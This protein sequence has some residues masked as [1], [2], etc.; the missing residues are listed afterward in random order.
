MNINILRCEMMQSDR[1][2]AGPLVK[3]PPEHNEVFT[4]NDEQES[5]LCQIIKAIQILLE[6]KIFEITECLWTYR[7]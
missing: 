5:N 3:G 6:L 7:P 1:A 4:Q 2:H